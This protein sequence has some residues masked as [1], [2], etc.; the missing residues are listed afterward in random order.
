MLLL[1]E[2]LV[3]DLITLCLR[4]DAPSAIEVVRQTHMAAAVAA[5]VGSA[6]DAVGTDDDW[7]AG[8]AVVVRDSVDPRARAQNNRALG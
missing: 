1:L 3:L 7:R 4:S 6:A 5:I 2:Y 8:A